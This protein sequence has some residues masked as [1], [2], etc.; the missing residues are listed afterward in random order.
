[1]LLLVAMLDLNFSCKVTLSV[2]LFFIIPVDVMA[3][4][5]TSPALVIQFFLMAML[6][7]SE[8]LDPQL[9]VKSTD[10]PNQE[11]KSM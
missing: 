5:Q 3:P 7:V 8:S 10:I 1:M 4:L 11:S 6:L 2:K 9:Y